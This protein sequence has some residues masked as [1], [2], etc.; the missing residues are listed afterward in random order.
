MGSVLIFR[1]LCLEEG[2]QGKWCP[3]FSVDT[4]LK[5]KK[6][7]SQAGVTGTGFSIGRFILLFLVTTHIFGLFSPGDSGQIKR[8]N[9]P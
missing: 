6:T 3:S 1:H 7:H 2:E 8:V 5:L 9:L 4:T